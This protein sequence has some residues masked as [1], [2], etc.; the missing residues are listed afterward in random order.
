MS[1]L[2]NGRSSERG[3]NPQSKTST[4]Q[5][6]HSPEQAEINAILNEKI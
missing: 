2:Y 4:V 6:K 5:E 3:N 1:Y